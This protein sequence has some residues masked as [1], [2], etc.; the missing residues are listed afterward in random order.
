MDMASISERDRILSQ[1]KEPMPRRA[2][3]VENWRA[4]IEQGIPIIYA[5]CSAGIVARYAELTGIDAIVVYETGLSRHW[6]MPT[7]MLADPNRWSF[8]MYEEIRSQVDKTPLIAGVEAYDPRFRGE[9]GLRRMV[10]TV[11][12]MGYDGIQ[13]FPTLVFIPPTYK[14]RDPVGMGWEREV[15][16]VA[17][18]NELDVFTMWYACTPEQAQDVARAGADAIVP[19]AGWSSGGKVGAPTTERY[20]NTMITPI[21]D[22]DVACRHVQAI[23]DAARAINPKII[24]LSHGGPFIDIPAVTYMFE[25]TTTDGF[26][27]ASAWERVPVENALTDVISRFRAVKKLRKKRAA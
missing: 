22:L 24:S 7:T 15:E 4:Q 17:L 23:T 9:R 6:G 16:L 19:H 27:A 14:L 26:E 10:R 1:L 11:I 13:N 25:H 2:E 12:E 8:P 20:P 21:K 3:I 5:G 18:C